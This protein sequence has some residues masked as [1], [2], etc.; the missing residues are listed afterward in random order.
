MCMPISRFRCSTEYAKTPAIPMA[1]SESARIPSM[2][3]I[4]A[5]M[6]TPDNRLHAV[7]TPDVVEFAVSPQAGQAVLAC[8]PAP[9]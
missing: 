4:M 9:N 1:I 3:A 5:P 8:P 6:R 7:R 2:P